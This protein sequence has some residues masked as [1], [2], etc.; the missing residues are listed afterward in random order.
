MPLA[1]RLH[2]VSNALGDAHRL[3]R[4]VNLLVADPD[5]FCGRTEVEQAITLADGCRVDLQRRALGAGARL[6]AEEPT[7]YAARLAGYR[8]VWHDLGD[9]PEVGGISAARLGLGGPEGG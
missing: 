4:L 3:E 1:E 8:R 9:E 6:F 7:A 2:D 5:V